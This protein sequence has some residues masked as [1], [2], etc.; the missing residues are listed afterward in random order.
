L[1]TPEFAVAN[2]FHKCH[3]RN[4]PRIDRVDAPTFLSASAE[5]HLRIETGPDFARTRKLPFS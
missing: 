2:P 5:Q 3:L 4:Q 1:R